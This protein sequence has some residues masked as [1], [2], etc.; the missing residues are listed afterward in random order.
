MT[1]NEV[2]TFRKLYKSTFGDMNSCR[3]SHCRASSSILIPYGMDRE[4]IINSDCF[5]CDYHIGLDGIFKE[6]RCRLINDSQIGDIIT[7]QRNFKLLLD[8]QQK[9]VIKH[10]T[11]KY[12]KDS[13]REIQVK[14][15]FIGVVFD[16]PPEIAVYNSD[17]PIIL[18]EIGF[19]CF[20]MFRKREYE[21]DTIK[22]SIFD[23][24]YTYE[25]M[26]ID[27]QKYVLKKISINFKANV[28]LH[29]DKKRLRS[30]EYSLSL[31]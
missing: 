21:I 18:P 14:K 7:L 31:L 13:G 26:Y 20:D 6:E 4:Q 19:I 9:V 25:K 12:I 17:N 27:F 2:N 10:N 28:Y 8:Q 16:N 29:Y 22:N 15:P 3:E 11:Y 30:T 5:W 24:S 1:T 23:Y